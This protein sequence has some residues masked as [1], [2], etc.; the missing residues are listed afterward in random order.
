[1]PI[2]VHVQARCGCW[3][4][5][6]FNCDLPDTG[7]PM[8]RSRM[9]QAHQLPR[10]CS[11]RWA[12]CEAMCI[13]REPS[14]LL[15]SIVHCKETGS[16]YRDP[17]S[18]SALPKLAYFQQQHSRFLCHMT[19]YYIIPPQDRCRLLLCSFSCCISS[20]SFCASSSSQDVPLSRPP[21]LVQPYLQAMGWRILAPH[22]GHFQQ[23]LRKLWCSVIMRQV[24]KY[25]KA[26]TLNTRTLNMLPNMTRAARTDTKSTSCRRPFQS[27]GALCS[28]LSGHAVMCSSRGHEEFL[29]AELCSAYILLPSCGATVGSLNFDIDQC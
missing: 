23:V 3:C 28:T 10:P 27:K 4:C 7:Q 6:I 14:L 9:L 21:H 24:Q 1:M 11:R 20:Y 17:K 8:A 2:I 25:G 15:Q 5:N 26:F 13:A 12:G 19:V 16:V 29:S 18:N 22:D